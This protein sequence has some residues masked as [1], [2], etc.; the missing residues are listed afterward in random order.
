MEIETYSKQKQLVVLW[1]FFRAL[2][3]MEP[4][5]VKMI[6]EQFYTPIRICK[7]PECFHIC[8]PRSRRLPVI[9]DAI[10]HHRRARH[11]VI[12]P[13]PERI[14]PAIWPDGTLIRCEIDA[15][16]SD[17]G[18]GKVLSYPQFYDYTLSIKAAFAQGVKA[19]C[20]D[21]YWG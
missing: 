14:P 12:E 5:L 7:F 18:C 17:T 16:G 6:E 19:I 4:E 11:G 2:W 8:A 20:S 21:C 1:W 15:H 3:E 9:R 13:N 10:K